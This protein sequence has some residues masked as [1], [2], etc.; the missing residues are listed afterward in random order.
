MKN[1]EKSRRY[2]IFYR[3]NGKWIGPYQGD[4]FTWY[5]SNTR[6]VREYVKECQNYI[7]KAK[8]KVMPVG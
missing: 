1:K 8:V 4:T 6:P 5:T 7:L 3:S 2:G